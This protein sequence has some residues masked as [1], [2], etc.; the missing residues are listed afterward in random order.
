MAVTLRSFA[1]INLGL[2]IG[3]RREDGFHELSTVYQTIA[4][5]DVVK[6]GVGRGQGIEIRCSDP[7]VPTSESNTCYRMAEAVLRALNIQRRVTIRIEKRLPVQGGLAGASS[8]A[9]A[10]LLGMER[11]MRRRI[12]LAK[13]LKLAAEIGS[14]LPLFLIGG[15]VMGTGRGERV[16]EAPDLPPLSCVV[17]TS[18]TGVSTP[19]AFAAWD[20]MAAP[21]SLSAGLTGQ[22]AS[23]RIKVFS[24]ML[25]RWLRGTTSGVPGANARDRAEALLLDLVRTGIGN[26]FEAVVFPQYPELREVKKALL[27]EGAGYA[28]LSGSGSAIYGLFASPRKAAQAA[29]GLREQGLKAEATRTLP[30]REYWRKM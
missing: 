21:S 15:T 11:A 29:A 1:K 20:K 27:R 28:S 8:N 3:P 19:A 14:D 30:G 25:R 4:L 9:V 23:D 22:A 26:D 18:E 12:S 7:R 10:T 24:R 6:V 16:A 5:H 17:V 2:T 13:K